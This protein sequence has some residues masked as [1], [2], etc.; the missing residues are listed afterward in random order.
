VGYVGHPVY[1]SW[2]RRL[3]AYVLDVLIIAAA[4]LLLLGLGYLV[5]GETGA[6]VAYV[7]GAIVGPGVYLTWFHGSERGATPGKRAAGIRVQRENGDRLGYGRALARWAITIVFAILL[8]IP[9][10]LDYL[11]PLW[12]DRNQALHDKVAGSVVVRA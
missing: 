9:L 11:W 6:A 10:L 8:Y 3:G 5:G 2:G 7:L 1:A 12:D 4:A